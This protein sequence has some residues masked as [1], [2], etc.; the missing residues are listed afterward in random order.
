MF[1]TYQLLL[2]LALH[3]LSARSVAANQ[4]ISCTPNLVN[5]KALGSYNIP[6]FTGPPLNRTVSPTWTITTNI[7]KNETSL[8]RIFY[9]DTHTDDI[10][11]NPKSPLRGCAVAIRSL[12]TAIENSG[13]SKYNGGA[14]SGLLDQ[15]CINA[16][17]SAAKTTMAS[18]VSSNASDWDCTEALATV[19]P[20][21]EQYTASTDYTWVTSQAG[22]TFSRPFVITQR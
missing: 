16:I 17:T 10:V 14:C 21:C 11:N 9:L 1:P 7:W 4:D 3:L 20:E 18:L 5:E 15:A 8:D 22:G 2:S 12:P 19:P 13:K 6:P